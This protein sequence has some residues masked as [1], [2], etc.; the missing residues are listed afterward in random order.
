MLRDYEVDSDDSA[1][2]DSDEMCYRLNYSEACKNYSD[3]WPNELYYS[4]TDSDMTADAEND[5][6]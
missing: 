2:M 1:L 5:Y 6:R 3:N 4:D